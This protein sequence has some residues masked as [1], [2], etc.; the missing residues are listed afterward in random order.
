MRREGGFTVIELLVVV[1]IL[2][3]IPV[4]LIG[5]V[6]MGNFWVGE[7]SALKAVQMVDPSVTEVVMLYR[8]VW[9]YS[10]VVVR[11]NEGNQHKFYL[12]ACILQ[13][14]T[15]IPIAPDS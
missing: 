15:A 4:G 6:V 1:I 12:D 14:T 10:R 3:I 8:H 13:N 9:G 5:G 2:G 11:D 7:A